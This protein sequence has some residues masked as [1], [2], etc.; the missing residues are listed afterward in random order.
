MNNP[1]N[2]SHNQLLGD[3]GND[4]KRTVLGIK[5]C[6]EHVFGCMTKAMVRLLTRGIGMGRTEGWRGV[7]NQ[8]FKFFA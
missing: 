1:Q 6:I 3:A 5:K 4:V 2:N 7:K 8:L